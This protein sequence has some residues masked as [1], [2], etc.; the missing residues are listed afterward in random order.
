MVIS[1]IKAQTFGQLPENHY[2]YNTKKQPNQN[3]RAMKTTSSDY[4]KEIKSNIKSINAA[5]K[6]IEESEKVQYES[7]NNRD[8]DWAQGE[9]RDANIDLM[10]AVEE[11]VRLASAMGCA[12]GLYDIHKYHRV[13]ELDFRDSRK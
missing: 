2:L 8:Y 6:R 5:M 10:S 3:R 4:I 12:S 11:I 13:V 1:K 9:S 7:R